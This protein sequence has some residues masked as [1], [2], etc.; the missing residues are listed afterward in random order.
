MNR[1]RLTKLLILAQTFLTISGYDLLAQNEVGGTVPENL[2]GPVGARA[3]GLGSAYVA[4]ANDPTAVYWNPAGLDL[5]EKQSASFYYLGLQFDT[6]HSFVGIAYPTLSIGTFG[7]GW[8]HL[9]T[10]GVQ[11]RDS[12]AQSGNVDDFSANELFFSYG[13]DLRDNLSIGTSVKLY[14]LGFGN[15]RDQ[16][17]R[18]DD[19]GLGLDLGMIYSPVFDMSLLRDISLG[20]NIQN[21]IAPS[22]RLRNRQDEGVINLK[23]GIS[24]LIG[25]G[26]AGNHMRLLFDIN[27]STADGAPTTFHLGSE[28]S[29]Q[30]AATLRLGYNN[31]AMAF[32][33]GA[34]YNNFRFDYNYGAF[35]EAD[36]FDP[37]HRLTITIDM[38]K[39]KTERMKIARE[40]REKALQI[41]VENE[42]W[43]NAE[44]D[45]NNS[46]EKGRE[47]YYDKE[48]LD[49]LVEFDNAVDAAET[50]QEISMR[51]RPVDGEDPEANMRVET[52]L[53]S[54]QEAEKFL[55][56]AE[57]RYDSLRTEN[58][59]RIMIAARESAVEQKL[60]DF[61]LEHKEKGIAFFKGGFY[62]KA[63]SEWQLSVDE[64]NTTNLEKLPQWVAEV[65]LELENNIKTAEKQLEGD[66]RDTI[67]KAKRLYDLG[68]VVQAINLLQGL[69]NSTSGSEREEVEGLIGRYQ[70]QMSFS[71]HFDEGMRLYE[72]KEW[73]RAAKAFENALKVRPNDKKTKEMYDEAYD[74][75]VATVINMPPQVRIKYI[76]GRQ[77]YREGKYREAMEVWEAARS[78]QPRNKVLLD[79][80][81]RAKAKL[82]E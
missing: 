67:K 10:S 17:E 37:G 55:Q 2:E 26:E 80:I 62:S 72:Q 21:L 75:S 44:T 23:A 8:W 3:L 79:A 71:Q 40:E 9:S 22:I 61:I 82:K 53:S 14:K 39:S 58:Q 69:L 6:A 77:L 19:T 7:F 56:L 38:G 64:I 57:V 76:R 20:V 35:F 59:K 52:A 12:Y 31:G 32:G 42:L 51:L 29:F 54:S 24:K 34:Q 25:F 60:R 13:K 18:I 63:I 49:A 43:V 48:Y 70:N 50:M 65:K 5:V 36:P 46:M 68:Q 15:V 16:G 78:D 41:R 45:F 66:T 27:T 81:D 73:T 33:A 1:Q 4:A 74:R 47:R 30:G 11:E 28:Y